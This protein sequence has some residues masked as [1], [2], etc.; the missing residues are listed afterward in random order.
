VEG[1]ES[2]DVVGIGVL[3][4]VYFKITRV[5]LKK[6]RWNVISCKKIDDAEF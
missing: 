1:R 2:G 4:G 6:D 3:G 5:A